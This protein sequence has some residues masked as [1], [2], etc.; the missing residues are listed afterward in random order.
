MSA[1]PAQIFASS[2]H[3]LST[4]W[5]QTKRDVLHNALT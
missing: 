1:P 3:A 5:N 4:T 2:D